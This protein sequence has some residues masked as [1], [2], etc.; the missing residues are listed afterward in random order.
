METTLLVPTTTLQCLFRR[1]SAQATRTE[2]R[3]RIQTYNV[4]QLTWVVSFLE[5]KQ[6]A[7][8]GMQTIL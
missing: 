2:L 3:S 5:V 1:L 7:V 6:E 4:S 8:M